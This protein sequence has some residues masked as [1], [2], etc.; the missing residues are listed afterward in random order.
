MDPSEDA[1]EDASGFVRVLGADG[2]KRQFERFVWDAEWADLEISSFIDGR[3]VRVLVAREEY[4][5]RWTE[6]NADLV[7]RDI[8]CFEYMESL[9]AALGV[10]SIE[11]RYA[12]HVALES[13]LEVIQAFT[14]VDATVLASTGGVQV[15]GVPGFTLTMR[16]MATMATT[17]RGRGSALVE[18]T[19]EAQGDSAVVRRPRSLTMIA[20]AGR[21][22][23][24]LDVARALGRLASGFAGATGARFARMTG[25]EIVRRYEFR[26][27]HGPPGALGTTVRCETRVELGVRARRTCVLCDAIAPIALALVGGTHRLPQS[28]AICEAHTT[29]SLW[30]V[31][32][33]VRYEPCGALGGAV[34][35]AVALTVV[36]ELCPFEQIKRMPKWR[37]S[38]WQ[39]RVCLANYAEAILTRSPMRR[40]GSEIVRRIVAHARALAVPLSK[41]RLLRK[42]KIHHFRGPTSPCYDAREDEAASFYEFLRGTWRHLAVIG[43]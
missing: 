31:R 7:V 32:F 2:D 37:M 34:A 28:V 16:P 26:P 22:V 9:G 33:G 27:R 4:E 5:A 36:P 12:M 38:A 23:P 35:R 24:L 3:V 30:G 8:V 18:V 25:A 41:E 17:R 39:R 6:D 14:R 42:H 19:V 1:S 29:A 20:G 13:W 40:F 21:D 43:A 15:R 10:M 11:E